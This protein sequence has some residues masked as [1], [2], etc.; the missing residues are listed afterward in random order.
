MY[1]PLAKG[2]LL[3]FLSRMSFQF[4]WAALPLLLLSS[5][6][7]CP[8][9][10]AAPV[11]EP[12]PDP[13]ADQADVLMR[14][15]GV[16]LSLSLAERT[17]GIR[18]GQVMELPPF[19]FIYH[20][21]KELGREKMAMEFGT[22]TSRLEQVPPDGCFPGL[23]PAE[24]VPFPADGP[25]APGCRRPGYE[26]LLRCPHQEAGRVI[27]Y[28]AG[29]T[30][31]DKWG[32]VLARKRVLTPGELVTGQKTPKPLGRLCHL[33]REII[34]VPVPMEVFEDFGRVRF[35]FRLHLIMDS[36]GATGP[37]D[38]RA[39]LRVQLVNR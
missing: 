11:N 23:V 26:Q 36:R 15:R 22:D 21:E 10:P 27:V 31:A 37:E 39:Y 13:T 38:P 6:T 4:P 5:A 32:K 3:S 34:S 16:W 12:P 33:D 17:S 20:A 14:E 1:R 30:F 29:Y 28:Y 24:L 19:S 8:G 7:G 9:W 25:Y 2:L 35:Q 18:R